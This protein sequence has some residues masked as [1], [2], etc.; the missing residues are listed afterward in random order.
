MSM[1][2]LA[3]EAQVLAV[4]EDPAGLADFM[5]NLPRLAEQLHSVMTQLK[6]WMKERRFHEEVTGPVEDLVSSTASM[7]DAATE[8]SEAFQERYGWLRATT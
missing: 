3:N 5:D 4:P 6:D 1:E 8:A 7:E 2:Q